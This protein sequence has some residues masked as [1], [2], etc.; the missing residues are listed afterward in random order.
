MKMRAAGT[1][2][3][4]SRESCGSKTRTPSASRRSATRMFV[5]GILARS[6]KFSFRSIVRLDDAHDEVAARVESFHGDLKRGGR[7]RELENVDRR[8]PYAH[9]VAA[10]GDAAGIHDVKV[11]WAVLPKGVAG[12]YTI[13]NLRPHR[14]ADRRS[15]GRLDREAAG[16]PDD[17]EAAAVRGSYRAAAAADDACLSRAAD[18][19]AAVH[20][21]PFVRGDFNG[22][23]VG[24]EVAYPADGR[25]REQ[26]GEE[27][28]AVLDETERRGAVVVERANLV[29]ALGPVGVGRILGIA[30]EGGEGLVVDDDERASGLVA[31]APNVGNGDAAADEVEVALP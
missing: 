31:A 24:E 17:G 19:D 1:R 22:E 16:D 18:R 14:P 12:A 20:L 28:R 13:G 9:A 2:E 26:R 30:Q 4:P 11:V 21:L 25:A 8:R 27:G 5:F 29:G 10:H 6:V 15:S 23:E 3:M 7:R